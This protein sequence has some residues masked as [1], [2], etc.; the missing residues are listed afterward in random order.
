MK[1]FER[2]F[3]FFIKKVIE[4]CV[5]QQGIQF[6]LCVRKIG[7]AI[8]QNI[9]IMVRVLNICLDINLFE[10]QVYGYCYYL[11]CNVYLF[12]CSFDFRFVF[13]VFYRKYLFIYIFINQIF[14]KD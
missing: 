4:V 7:I 12:S 3:L 6:Q 9:D 11:V 13:L 8:V 5:Q 14:S 1:V 2:N 10:I